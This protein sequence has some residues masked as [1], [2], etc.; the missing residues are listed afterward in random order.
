[1]GPP[2]ALAEAVRRHVDAD[3]ADLLAVLEGCGEASERASRTAHL[4]TVIG[5]AVLKLHRDRAAERV[6]PEGRIGTLDGDAIDGDV[7]DEIP[8]DRVAEGLVEARPVQIDREPLRIAAQR[9]GL[10]A[11]IEHVRLERIVLRV[12]E[13]DAA[14]ALLEGA[15]D[16][17]LSR[18]RHLGAGDDAGVHR[19]LVAIDARAADWR[20]RD[21]LDFGKGDGRSALAPG[22]GGDERNASEPEPQSS[23]RKAPTRSRSTVQEKPPASYSI[24]ATPQ[25][26]TLPQYAYY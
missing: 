1:M 3:V 2:S 26:K 14:D 4:G 9:R 20:R 22:R 5:E 12:V 19:H 11:A 17:R 8:V 18:P 15:Q 24:L 23:H 10:I 21:H 13:G 6:Q 7:R 25:S 16:A